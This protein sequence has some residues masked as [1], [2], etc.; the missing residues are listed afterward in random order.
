MRGLC[1]I[2]SESWRNITCPAVVARNSAARSLC[3]QWCPTATPPFTYLNLQRIRGFASDYTLHD[4]NLW[5]LFL[6]L[7][8]NKRHITSL[9]RTSFPLHW[10]WT[11]PCLQAPSFPFFSSKLQRTWTEYGEHRSFVVFATLN[12]KE[13]CRKRVLIWLIVLWPPYRVKGVNSELPVDFLT[14]RSNL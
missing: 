8:A 9:S 13:T 3:A 2:Q 10:M 14:S 7:S 4:T 11:S 1:S 5:F 6:C 12:H